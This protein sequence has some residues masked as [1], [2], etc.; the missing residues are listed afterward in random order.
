MKVLY[1]C[2]GNINRSAAAETITRSKRPRW[3]VRSAATNLKGDQRMTR[4]MREALATAGYDGSRHRSS[5]LSQELCQWAD[6]IV[7]FQPSHIR[8]VETLGYQCRSIL[9]WSNKQDWTKVPDPHFDSTGRLHLEVVTFLIPT[10]DHLISQ[11]EGQ[12]K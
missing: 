2:T 11:T 12:I 6:L 8:A 7:G 3:R 5:P 1:V 10:L 9:D 4:R